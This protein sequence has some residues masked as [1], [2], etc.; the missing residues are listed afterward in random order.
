MQATMA[1]QSSVVAISKFYFSQVLP[2]S[3][4]GYVSKNYDS[5]FSVILTLKITILI[6]TYVLFILAVDTEGSY[7]AKLYQESSNGEI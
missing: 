4:C 6:H 1:H 2:Q 7:W 5:S 3:L